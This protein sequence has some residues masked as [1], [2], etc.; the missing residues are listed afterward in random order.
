MAR[1][2]VQTLVGQDAENLEMTRSAEGT[3]VK[4][5]GL[6]KPFPTINI[7]PHWPIGI[8]MGDAYH[9]HQRLGYCL[10]WATAAGTEVYIADWYGDMRPG[11]AL[12]VENAIKLTHKDLDYLVDVIAVLR[13][14]R[15][16]D[17]E[18]KEGAHRG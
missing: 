9:P 10:V 11:D 18:T 12:F 15:V 14:V 6:P 17:A 5:L 16:A 1:F 7:E 4:G 13:K 2:C 8:W 3:V